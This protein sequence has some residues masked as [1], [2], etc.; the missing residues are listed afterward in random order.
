MNLPPAAPPSSPVTVER[1]PV[2]PPEDPLLPPPNLENRL[3]IPH[4]KIVEI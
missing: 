4:V 2:R 1:A 3:A